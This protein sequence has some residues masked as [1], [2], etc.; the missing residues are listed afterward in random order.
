MTGVPSPLLG[1]LLLYFLQAQLTMLDFNK[2]P[3]PSGL[4]QKSH[5]YGSITFVLTNGAYL[6]TL[7]TARFGLQSNSMKH[8][9]VV[10]Y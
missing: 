2:W 6:N 8:K 3:C 5:T 4:D 7:P 10:L 9:Y 1:L